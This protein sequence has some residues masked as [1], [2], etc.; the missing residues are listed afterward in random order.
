MKKILKITGIIV[1]IVVLAILLIPF[2]FKGKISNALL[3]KA[4]Q[5]VNAEISYGSF[6]LSLIKSFPDFNASFNNVAVVGLDEFDGDTLFAFRNLS[7]QLDIR[8]VWSG[9][10]LVLKSLRLD[11]ALVQL[12][13]SENGAVNWAIAQTTTS[14]KSKTETESA[15][16]SVNLQLREIELS[17]FNFIYNSQKLGFLFSILHTD[18]SMSGALSGN[19]TLLDIDA[20]TPSVSF[21][22]DS[23]RYIENGTFNLQ[24]RLVADF[25]KFE[26]GFE[27]GKTSVNEML[28]SMDGGFAMPGDSLVFDLGFDV[29]EIDIHQLLSLVP[30]AFKQ[31]MTDIE[32]SGKVDF[33]GR[34]KGIYFDDIYPEINVGLNVSDAEI[35]YPGLPESIKLPVLLAQVAKPEGDLDLLTIGLEKMTMQMAN[36][37]FEMQ[38]MFGTLFSDPYIDVDAKGLIDLETVNK[39]IPLGDT[40]MTGMLELD[41]Q[42]KGNYSSLEQNDFASF[43]SSGMATLNNFFIQNSSVPQG[44]TLSRAALELRDQDITLR[45]LAGNIGQSDFNLDGKLTN[46]V[47]WLFANDEL[48]GRMNLKSKLLNLNEFMTLYT[49]DKQTGEADYIKTDSTRHDSILLTLPAKMHLVFDAG[50][51]RLLYDQMDITNFNGML[52]LHNQQ[53]ELR[54]LDMQLMG[55]SMKMDGLLVADG[56]QNPTLDARLEIIG[57]DLPTA[58]QQLSVVQKYLPFA[59]KSQ[60]RFSSGLKLNT[61]LNSE[62]K[63]M[64]SDL[65][66]SG[67]FSSKNLKLLNTDIFDK[68]RGVVKSSYFKNVSVDDFTTGFAIENGNLEVEPLSTSIAGQAVQLSGLYNIG[69]TLDFRVDAQVEKK[70]LSD[71][72][73]NIIAYIP[74]HQKVTSVD[75]GF[76]IKGDA[77]K[78]DVE[79]DTEKIKKQV[80][81]QVKG[82]SLDEIEDA[83][84]KLLKDLFK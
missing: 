4:K 72:I 65:S 16:A 64:L 61:S 84:K 36:N 45:N 54:G 15:G 48:K 52:V 75:V 53:L 46:V 70:V 55:G 69:G 60:G 7:V 22:Y 23:V 8:S 12:I 67:S 62:M 57:F 49:P 34:V 59:A 58:Y 30:D 73:Q 39:V 78:P 26:F 42:M 32:A 35:K 37:P 66:A 47:T 28:V 71:D 20:T 41:A 43:V 44:V 40:K 5:N 3:S 83:A 6:Q 68:L 17:D 21:G 51:N 80:L 74:G 77:K 81:D 25:E 1:F 14:D 24:S 11:K 27:A 19:T 18:V 76:N 9:E 50:I 33:G 31:Y 38:A 10:N 29:P 2:A 82:S 56:R 63:T 13:Q 79:V